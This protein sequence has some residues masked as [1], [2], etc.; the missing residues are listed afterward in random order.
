MPS[1]QNFIEGARHATVTPD[2]HGAV[3]QIA[4]WFL[5]VVMILATIPRLTIRSTT[6]HIPRLDD[7]LVS[8]A[9][10][11]FGHVLLR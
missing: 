5:L 4:A 1:P 6:N 10:V 11:S 2:D 3:L 9:M 8:L 7:V